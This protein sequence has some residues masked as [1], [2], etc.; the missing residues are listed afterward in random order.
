[1]DPG[2]HSTE[3][4]DPDVGVGTATLAPI[5]SLWSKIRASE[6]WTDDER[7][8][9]LDDLFPDDDTRIPYLKRFI[10]L[11]VLSTAIAAFGLIANSAA[12]VIGAM[13]VAP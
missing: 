3:K 7:D 4:D 2:Q 10:S 11:I 12:V 13:L 9:V 1:M 8:A 5:E 6:E